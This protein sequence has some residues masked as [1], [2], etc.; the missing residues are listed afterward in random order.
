VLFS[1]DEVAG[2]INQN[3]EA[4]WESVRPVPIVRVDFG[5]GTILTRT[6]H[7][8]IATYVCTAK[9]DV[10]DVLPGIYEPQAYVKALEQFR[11]LHNY[12]E[13]SGNQGLARLKEYHE[14]QV[15]ALKD[16]HAP[17]Q[18]VNSAGLSKR[19]IEGGILAMLVSAEQAQKWTLQQPLTKKPIKEARMD[20]KDDI[21][22]W[23]TLA[24]DTHINE[25]IRRLQIHEMLLAAG[26]V[27]PS[28]ITKRLYKEVLHSDLD[29]PYLGLGQTLFAGYPFAREDMIR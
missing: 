29:D 15:K 6:L 23:K 3:F 16:N 24:E 9:G 26:S 2:F 13:R 28:S 11:L 4:V 27:Q 17:P 5:N 18:F 21:A 14:G 10:L 19:I 1:R 20:S 12:I 22:N 25:S 7:G 8:N